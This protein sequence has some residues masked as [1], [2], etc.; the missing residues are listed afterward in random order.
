M[1]LDVG[2][3]AWIDL[4]PVRGTE[5][6]GRRPGLVL[7]SLS[8]HQRCPR[9]VVCPI[10]SRERPWGFNVTLPSGLKTRGSILVDQVRALERSERLFDIIE[11]AP[12]SVVIEVRAVLAALLGFDVISS[13]AES[14]ET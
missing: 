2:D 11:R 14:D 8:Y 10:T 9:V 7:T 5:Q 6:A 13:I 12:D 3:I 4:D 1:L